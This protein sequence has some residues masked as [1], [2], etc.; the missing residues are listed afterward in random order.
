VTSTPTLSGRLAAFATRLRFDDLPSSVTDSVADRIM[1]TLGICIA[2]QRSEQARAVVEV[3]SATGGTPQATA[4]G[5]DRRL[6]ATA[7]ALVNGTLAHSL[8]YDDTHLPSI[9]HPSAVLVPA[10][11]AA[12]ELTGASGQEL[13]VALAAG[14][15]IDVRLGMAAY[16]PVTRDNV[17][18]E[19][20]LHATSIC[21]SLASAVVTARLLS[22]S[23]KQTR[24]ALGIATS[25]GAGLIEANRAGGSVKQLHC[26]L[27]AQSGIQAALLARAGFTAPDTALEGR[28]GF[29]HALTG[30]RYDPRVVVDGLG[31]EWET[32]KIFF[33][34]YP[35]NHFTHCGIDAA[36]KLR[37][38]PAFR[39]SE[40]VR[41]RLGV[42]PATLR[43]IAEPLQE[44]LRPRS[45]YH[46]KFSGPFTVATALLRGRAGFAEFT[47][48]A[49]S[50][51]VTLALAAKVECMADARCGAIYPNQFPAVLA[52]EMTSG[53]TL[54]EEVWVNR[55]GPESPLSPV[56]LRSKFEQNCA[57]GGA[58]DRARAILAALGELPTYGLERVWP[59]I[60]GSV[61][62]QIDFS[63]AT[64]GGKI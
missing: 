5:S 39:V 36:L 12:A 6:P 50:D 42:A 28:F 2:A 40:V 38:N 63:S 10:G 27:A 11:I 35:A 3:V 22:L 24:D 57:A 41:L 46:A 45:G 52:A 49:T 53:E 16:D 31:E 19:R 20:G 55:G 37:A 34:P 43:T 64:S 8:D 4:I 59:A 1:D 13:I 17:F 44:K 47:D 62:E 14:Y 32:P 56:A 58:G 7:A 29:Y 60:Q 51:P 54:V 33:K 15:E 61:T 30:D 26:G 23:E 25:V 21:G 18:F 9:L 48:E